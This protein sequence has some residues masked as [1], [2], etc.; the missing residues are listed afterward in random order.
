M[1]GLKI[2]RVN[3]TTQVLS[4]IWLVA[5]TAMAA[6][7]AANIPLVK[8]LGLSPLLLAILI[9]LFYGNTL[10]S[11]LPS[12][13]AHGV[14]YCTKYIL[15][16]AIILLGFSF[17]FQQIAQQGLLG[18][19]ADIIIVTGTLLLGYFIGTRLL[20]MDPEMALMCSIGPAICGASAV[21][22]AESVLRTS[23]AKTAVAVSTVVLFGTISMFLYPF[24]Y[25]YIPH[26]L[27]DSLFGI[28]IGSSIH[29]VP[30]VVA[31]GNMINADVAQTA[32]I[33]KMARV[34]LLVPVL[35]I[36]GF[37]WEKIRTPLPDDNRREQTDIIPWWAFA[38]VAAVA[39]NS[40]ISIPK[41]LTYS[42]HS[43]DIFLLTMAMGAIGMETTVAKFEEVGG[44]PFIL[45]SI[46]FVWLV[47]GGWAI[48]LYL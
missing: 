35:L 13:W 1:I 44:K 48:A 25:A 27:S 37:I 15:R 38:F 2:F 14:R 45:T 10:S 46:L 9:G 3:G 22:A 30:Q 41:E 47:A 31:A 39:I 18:L 24:I 4:G 23:H 8:A 40:M 12:G 28:Y 36:I 43:V 19:I 33:V 11:Q 5:L 32:T 29:E 21:L 34:L 7:Y 20:K 17:T 42:I 6:I 16:L 26:Q